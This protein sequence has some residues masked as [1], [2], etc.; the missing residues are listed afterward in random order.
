MLSLYYRDELTMKQ[1]SEV[2]GI[3]VSRVSQI[4]SAALS[5]LRA[6]LGPPPPAPEPPQGKPKPKPW[7][8]LGASDAERSVA[9][10]G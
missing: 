3:A 8:R 2:V 9:H 7:K 10:A 4:H 1:V 6:A 5:K